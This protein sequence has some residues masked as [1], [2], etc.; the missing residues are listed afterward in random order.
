MFIMDYIKQW[1]KQWKERRRRKSILKD[2]KK[3]KDF[4]LRHE[5]SYMCVCFSRVDYEKY[6]EGSDQICERIPEFNREFLNA[7]KKSCFYGAWWSSDDR[8]SR[9]EAFD[10][11]IEIYS[12]N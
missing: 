12:R 7:N 2:I 11:L 6:G 4:Y 9:I 3:A 1:K 5:S 10:K 8:K